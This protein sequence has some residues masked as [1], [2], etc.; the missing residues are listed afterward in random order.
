M[1]DEPVNDLLTLTDVAEMSGLAL[2][3]V[4]VYHTQANKARR[5]GK[6]L[7]TDLPEPDLIVVRTPTWRKATIEG[8]LEARETRRRDAAL[9]GEKWAQTPDERQPTK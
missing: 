4:R 3:S 2:G 7:P 1:E 6:S 9:A 8:W 5:A